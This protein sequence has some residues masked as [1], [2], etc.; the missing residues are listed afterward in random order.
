MKKNIVIFASGNG[1]NFVEIY[2]NVKMRKI[3]G[4][5]KLLITNNSSF[6]YSSI[7]Y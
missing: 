3:N 6:S 4:V 7:L 2:K 5:I 1:S